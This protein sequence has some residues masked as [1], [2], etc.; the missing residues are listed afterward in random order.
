M[1]NSREVSLKIEFPYDPVIPL[2]G[3]YPNKTRIQKDTC[4]SMFIAELFTIAKTWKPLKCPST[5]ERMKKMLYTI[6]WGLPW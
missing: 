4:T 2:R 1:E 5:G 6:E 3:I